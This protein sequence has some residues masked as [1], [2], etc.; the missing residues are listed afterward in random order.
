MRVYFCTSFSA[1]LLHLGISS[2]S[3]KTVTRRRKVITSN[4]CVSFSPFRS[5]KYFIRTFLWRNYF[6]M[7]ISLQHFSFGSSTRDNIWI[8]ST[9]QCPRFFPSLCTRGL[10]RLF[11]L[12]IHLFISKKKDVLYLLVQLL[13]G[14]CFIIIVFVLSSLI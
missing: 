1:Q 13:G 6:R 2:R 8:N 12:F 5:V 11:Y 10:Y 3:Y 14:L 9:T 4:G 7:Y